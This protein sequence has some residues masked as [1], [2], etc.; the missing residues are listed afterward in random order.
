VDRFDGSK[1]LGPDSRQLF[2]RMW[3]GQLEHRIRQTR[4]C[5]SRFAINEGIYVCEIYLAKWET[6]TSSMNLGYS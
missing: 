2:A 3:A 6:A 5:L 4:L 1:I